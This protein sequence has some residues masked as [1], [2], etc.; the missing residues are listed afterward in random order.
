ME[1]EINVTLKSGKEKA[2]K[3]SEVDAR[4]LYFKLSNLFAPKASYQWPY[5]YV[6]T[7]GSGF[8]QSSCSSQQALG[9]QQS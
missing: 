9:Q 2:I 3:L 5:Q 7:S 4:E 6:T 1:I 8:L